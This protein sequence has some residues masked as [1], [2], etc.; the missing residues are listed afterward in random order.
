[1]YRCKGF[2]KLNNNYFKVYNAQFI[3]IIVEKEVSKM[4]VPYKSYD[5]TIQPFPKQANA[6]YLE[7]DDFLL[8]FFLN[9]LFG[10]ISVGVKTFYFYQNR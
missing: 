3:R 7:T 1:M 4:P 5:T 2:L 8:L 6:I 10:D 9:T